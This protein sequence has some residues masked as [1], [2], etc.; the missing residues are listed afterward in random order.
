MLE[1]I[2]KQAGVRE[3]SSQY[4]LLPPR[5]Q[6]ALQWLVVALL[7]VFCIL[8]SGC[9]PPVITIARRHRR[10]NA[11]PASDLDEQQCC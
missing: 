6:K 11:A 7:A 2:K 4:L 8:H 10:L 5:D 9:S 3:T 1:K